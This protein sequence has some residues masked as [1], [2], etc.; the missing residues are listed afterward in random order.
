MTATIL[1]FL[2]RKLDGERFSRTGEL[3]NGTFTPPT[4]ADQELD[5]LLRSA[6]SCSTISTPISSRIA[7]G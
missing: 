3:L 4:S 2:S 7:M 5:L 1:N 6:A